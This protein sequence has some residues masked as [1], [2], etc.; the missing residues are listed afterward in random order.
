[1]SIGE[2]LRQF[3]DSKGGIVKLAIEMGI[4]QPRL[5]QYISEK[6]D[7]SSEVFEL[8]VSVGCDLNWLI[9]GKGSP[10]FSTKQIVSNNPSLK[11]LGSIP[12]GTG[13]MHL[14]DYVGYETID[15]DPNNHELLLIDKE[16]GDSMTPI[17]KPGDQVLVSYKDPVF[18]GCIVAAKW[19][20]NKGAVKILVYNKDMPDYVILRSLNQAEEPIFL[21]KKDV[22]LYRVVAWFDKRKNK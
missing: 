9:T 1:M 5:S 17:F 22:K 11:L 21:K 4:S 13:E 16:T 7:I 3:A 18:D 19:G 12:A 20:N 6:N 8:L 10:N 2:R 14:H 15:I